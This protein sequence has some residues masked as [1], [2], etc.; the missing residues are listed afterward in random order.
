MTIPKLGEQLQADQIDYLKAFRK[1]CAR[2]IIEMVKLSV[3]GND[4]HNPDEPLHWARE[5]STDQLDC[6]ARHLFDYG[7]AEDADDLEAQI[8]EMS[9]VMW[10]AGAKLQLL[11]EERDARSKVTS[12]AALVAKADA[13]LAD[14]VLN[15]RDYCSR[16]GCRRP[17]GSACEMPKCPAVEPDVEPAPAG[18]DVL[19]GGMRI[20]VVINNATAMG[21]VG[22]ANGKHFVASQTVRAGVWRVLGDGW[23]FLIYPSDFDMDYVAVVQE[24]N[25][26]SATVGDPNA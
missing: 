17:I 10:R 11:C 8:Q 4:K 6:I 20:R 3:E 14:K 21:L 5:K 19:Q 9:S 16:A 1:S 25:G 18:D 2:T 12:P 7:V 26:W 23:D 22:V 24:L 13:R 15:R